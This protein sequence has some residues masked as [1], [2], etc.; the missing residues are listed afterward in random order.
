MATFSGCSLVGTI[1]NYTLSAASTGL[2]GTTSASFTLAIGNGAR[3]VMTTNPAGA[4]YGVAF[5]TQP[6]VTV[7]DAGGNTVTTSAASV[8]LAINTQ[9]G[10]GASLSCTA[11]PV[12][13]VNGIATFAG[14]NLT[15]VVGGYTL[16]AIAATATSKTVS[17]SA[18]A[19]G[20][21]GV[22]LVAG[23]G[24]PASR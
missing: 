18:I 17:H 4:V 9:P 15:G 19:S 20:D 16:T 10:T 23:G 5:T 6:V 2:T 1:G 7:V 14:C 11:N 13:A 24:A 12:T 3:L 21:I 22:T 8:S